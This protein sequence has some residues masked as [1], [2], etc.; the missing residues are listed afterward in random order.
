MFRNVTVALLVSVA[1][2]LAAEELAKDKEFRGQDA[3]RVAAWLKVSRDHAADYQLAPQDKPDAP[4]KMLPSAVFRHS[5][6]VRGDDIGA[7]YLWVDESGLPAALGT[8]F[9]YSYGGPGER[10]VAHEFHSLASTPL[11]GKWRGASAWSPAEPGAQWKEVPEAPAP[12]QRETARLRQMRDIGRRL[13]AHT[14]DSGDS[15]WELRLLTQPIYQYTAQQPSDTL[16]GGVFLFC[17]GTDPE[18]ILLLEARRAGGTGQAGGK[19]AWHYALAP[20]T[21]Y[22]VS[23]T[24]DGKEAWSLARGH[25]PTRTSAH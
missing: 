15:R 11:V 7:V 21:D 12:S 10:W 14:T 19:P 4:L 6:P 1:L 5:Q 9:A 20:F 8:V 13:A 23:V 18:V 25:R 16:G 24:L 22:G 17:Q 3:Q 2:P